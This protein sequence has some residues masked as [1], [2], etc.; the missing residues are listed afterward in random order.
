MR[1]QRASRTAEAVCFCRALDQLPPSDARLVD[2]RYA[3]WFLTPMARAALATLE[4]S[5][6]VGRRVEQLVGDGSKRWAAFTDLPW[7]AS[8]S[9][10][11]T[12]YVLVRHR[13]MD[14]ALRAALDRGVEQ[15]LVLGAGYDSRAFR[16]A[17]ALDGRPI[18]ELDFPSTSERKGQVLSEHADELPQVDL[19]RVAIDFQSE[20]LVDALARSGFEV[21]RS[22]FVVWE[23]VAMYLPRATV[24]DTL[25]Q[26]RSVVG[27]GSELVWDL[28]YLLDAPDLSATAYRVTPSLLHVLGEP[29]VFAMHP[30]DLP[31]F[32]RREGL[33]AIEVAEAPK[34]RERYLQDDRPIYPTVYLSHAR[35]H[36]G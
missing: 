3:A 6:W 27:P 1:A 18:Y 30:E 4:A 5:S 20:R 9:P 29:I 31:D 32:C 35:L 22:T 13:Y 7:R 21:G 19:R 23:G 12:T 24:Q 33:E 25:S 36:P 11:L 34:L 2:D 10:A 16:F 28:W 17:E 26:L 15:V 8:L 14:D